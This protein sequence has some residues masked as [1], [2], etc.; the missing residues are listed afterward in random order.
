MKKIVLF[1]G[2]ILM[3][4]T[5]SAQS[6][7]ST[8]PQLTEIE[9]GLYEA[10]YVNDDQTVSQTGFYKIEDDKLVKHGVWKIHDGDKVITKAK[11]EDDNL[12]WIKSNGVVHT[13]KDIELLQLK[14]RVRK[15]ES[16]LVMR[17]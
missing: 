4:Y 15:L 1:V 9:E 17:D 11:F 16:T 5:V 10:T 2:I 8:S 12:V 6:Q 13:S 14:N 3:S 7:K